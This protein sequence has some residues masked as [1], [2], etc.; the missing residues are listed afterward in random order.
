MVYFGLALVWRKMAAL[1]LCFVLLHGTLWASSHEVRTHPG[2]QDTQP[3]I[4][5]AIAQLAARIAEPISKAHAKSVLVIDLLGP[6]LHS[7]PLG[8]WLADQ[9]AA[10]LRRDFPML[11]IADRSQTTTTRNS[12]EARESLQTAINEGKKQARALGA[13][14]V[15]LGSFAGLPRGIGITLMAWESSDNGRRFGEANGLVPLSNEMTAV[16]HGPI[17]SFEGGIARAG[18]GGITSPKCVRCPQPGYTSRARAAKYQ[19]TVVL[20][21]VV[22]AEGRTEKIVVVR[23]PGL[24]LEEMSIK[25]V[26]GWRLQPSRDPDGVPVSARTEVEVTFKLF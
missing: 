18:L 21:V 1:A 16:S 13:S 9:L 25:A 11:Q 3:T 12:N 23:G 10:S 24:G 20:D 19:G 17:P 22:N 6:E 26:S 2:Q 7:H 14:T 15:I 5:P 4:A 8:S